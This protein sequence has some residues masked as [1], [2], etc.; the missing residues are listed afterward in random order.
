MNYKEFIIGLVIL[1]IPLTVWY[2]GCEGIKGEI[3]A[4]KATQTSYDVARSNGTNIEQTAI[5]IDIAKQNRRLATLKY[6]KNTFIGSI[7][8]PD[9]LNDLKPIR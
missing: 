4:F 1:L 2:T 6:R 3:A 8:L 7:V 5:Q 9:E